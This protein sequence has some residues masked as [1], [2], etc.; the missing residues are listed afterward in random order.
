LNEYFDSEAGQACQG[1][2]EACDVYSLSGN[3]QRAIAR[4]ID[5]VIEQAAYREAVGNR[6]LVVFTTRVVTSSRIEEVSIDQ[7]EV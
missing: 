4:T 2:E 1:E 3:L 5:A 6:E 7:D